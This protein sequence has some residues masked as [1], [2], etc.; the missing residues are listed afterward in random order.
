MTSTGGFIAGNDTV[1]VATTRDPAVLRVADFVSTLM[2]NATGVSVSGRDPS[3]AP[4]SSF[5][6]TLD[7][8][9]ATGDEG[10]ELTITAHTATLKARTAAGLFYG[11]QTVRQLLPYASEYGALR[12]RQ[13]GSA[14]LPAVH[15]VDAPRYAWRGAMLDVA[16][17]FFAVDDVKRF[18][19][20]MALHKLN[21]L[22]LHLSDD[23]GWRIEIRSRPELTG[24]GASTQV[25]GGRGGFYTQAQYAEIV[26]YAAERFI[27]IV[28][29]IDMPGHTN[30]ALSSYAGAQLQ[31]RGRCSI[32]RHS[33]RLQRALHRPRHDVRI[34]RRRGSRDR[35]D[36]AGRLLPRGGDEVRTLSRE[37]Y[38]AF[39]ERVQQIVA[40][41][42][43]TM[44]GWDEIASATLLPSSIVQHWRPQGDAAAT[45][46]APRT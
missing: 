11:A 31:R 41:H 2:R 34:H 15:I 43:K 8:A 6:L 28:P 12:F 4:P 20:L 17:H 38:T 36:D 35:G 30:A 1:I 10:Y 3:A 7:P 27:T 37:A 25:G 29:E 44:I 13:P 23:Q 40:A 18:V 16:R 21:R 33:R 26:A 39:V 22:H 24:I 45:A 42:G 5:T 9:A 19:D 32:H 46:R 14:T